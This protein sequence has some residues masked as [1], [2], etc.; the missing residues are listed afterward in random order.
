[1][2]GPGND[3]VHVNFARSDHEEMLSRQ[4]EHLYNADFGDTLVT[5]VDVEQSSY[6]KTDL[7]PSA[8]HCLAPEET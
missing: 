2:D 4:L 7:V 6:P 1:M 8:T 5:L 3:G